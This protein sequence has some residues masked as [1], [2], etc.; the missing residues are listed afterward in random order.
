MG[1]RQ[2]S[3]ERAVRPPMRSLG[4]PPHQREVQRLFWI[5]IGKDCCP[6]RLPSW[7]V[8]RSRS[9]RGGSTT[10][11]GMPPLHLEPMSG[12]H[13]SFSEREEIAAGRPTRSMPRLQPDRGAVRPGHRDPK[14]ADG[15][16][17]MIRM[18]K[19]A[20]ASGIKSRGQAI[21]RLKAVFVRT[22][23]SLRESMAGLTNPRLFRVCADLNPV[24]PSDPASAAVFTLRLLARRILELT[25]AIDELNRRIAA[26]VAA[27]A[28]QLLK[29]YGVGHDTAAALLV[30]AG[31][32]PERL[33][34][35]ASFAALC[36]VSPIDASSG[37]T[38]RR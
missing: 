8:R 25:N 2:Q 4:T 6:R 14:S 29:R 1:R 35:E 34:S 27:R 23:P 18:F 7:S 9:G 15:H 36:G 19:L 38:Q 37:K 33:A 21:N 30:T 11:G 12:R 22:D 16:V 28:P 20:K 24:E 10:L 3:A 17:E 31:D 13:L 32:N 26:A 5:E